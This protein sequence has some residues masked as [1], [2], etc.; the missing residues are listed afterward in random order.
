MPT[1]P[2]E[3]I[4]SRLLPAV[5]SASV[6]APGENTPVF[7]SPVKVMLGVP[8]APSGT[9]TGNAEVIPVVVVVR[10]TVPPVAIPT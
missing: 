9:S 5:T 8:T 3:V 7:K 2:A 1:S 4:C 10:R 6:S